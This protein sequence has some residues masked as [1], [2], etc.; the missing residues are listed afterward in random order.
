MVAGYSLGVVNCLAYDSL[1]ERER[2]L[3]PPKPLDTKKWVKIF[4][5]INT[6]NKCLL[7]IRDFGMPVIGWEY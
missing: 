2:D 3:L 6:C 1:H 7:L 4:Y 5:E